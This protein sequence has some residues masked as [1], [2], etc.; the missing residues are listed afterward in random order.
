MRVLHV[1]PGGAVQPAPEGPFLPGDQPEELARPR[2]L[3]PQMPQQPGP[4]LPGEPATP[5]ADKPE[6]PPNGERAVLLGA[7]RNAVRLRNWDQALE[8]FQ[9][10]F[11]RFGTDELDARKEYLGVLVQAGR[12]R[13]ALQEYLRLLAKHPKDV[14]LRLDA[15]DIAVLNEKYH[16]AVTILLPALA[17]DPD[18][19]E[20]AVR[21]ARAYLLEDNFL[22]AV[23]VREH[24]PL[25]SLRPDDDKVPRLFP[26]L[27]LD[28]ERPAEALAFVLPLRKRMAEDAEVLASEIRIYARLC[29]HTHADEALRALAALGAGAQDVRLSLGGDLLA[30]EEFSLACQAYQQVLQIEQEAGITKSEPE[31]DKAGNGKE[32]DKPEPATSPLKPEVAIGRAKIGLARVSMHQFQPQPALMQL[33]GVVPNDEINRR[34]LL[35]WAEYHQ[36]VG[37]VIEAKAIYQKILCADPNDHE[38]RY[39]LGF[40]FESQIGEYQKAIAEYGKVPKDANQYRLAQIGIATSLTALRL[41]PEAMT[42]MKCLLDEYPHDGNAMAR[43]IRTMGKAGQGREAVPL[44][45]EFIHQNAKNPRAVLS[46]RLA[47]GQALLDCHLPQDA[48]AEYQ[49]ALDLP[50]SKIPETYYGLARAAVL[51][52]EPKKALQF[53]SA[54]EGLVGGVPRN[55]LLLSDLFDSDSD[56][57][58]ALNMV[59]PVVHYD[60][61][62]LAALIRY[63]RTQSRLARQS[64][65]IDESV[66]AAQNILKRSP[67]NVLGHIELARTFASGQHFIESAKAY[68]VLIK[69]DPSLRRPRLERARVLHSD[70]HFAEAQ[71]AYHEL[72][73]PSAEEVLEHDMAGFA[74]IDPRAKAVIGI[75]LA[76]GNLH[77]SITKAI[78]SSDPDVSLAL[79]RIQLDY[80]RRIAEQTPDRMEANDKD[81]D[82]KHYTTIKNASEVLAIEPDNNSVMFDLAQQYSILQMTH[83]AVET[84]NKDLEISPRERE[85]AIGSERATLEMSPQMSILGSVYAENGRNGLARITRLRGEV[86]FKWP[87]GDENEYLGVG[88]SRV[89]YLPHIDRP[90]DGNI[91]SGFYQGK[92]WDRLFFGGVLN[93][94]NY[95]DRISTRPTFDVD[96]H[97]AFNDFVTL[98]IGTF[99]NNVVENG[100]SM[101]QDIY[102]YAVRFG[103]DLTFTR[104]WTATGVINFGHYSD[105]NDYTEIFARSDYR[106]TLPPK[107][108]KLILDAD[109]LSYHFPSVFPNPNDPA[110]VGVIHPYFSPLFFLYYEAR[111]T[112][113]HWLS[114]D[115]F[116]HSNQCW[117]Q[118]EYALGFDNHVNM[119]N[120]LRAILNWDIKPWLS[121]GGQ[122]SCQLSDVYNEG[123]FLFYVTLRCPGSFHH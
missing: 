78:G 46:V 90:L 105:H 79:H 8:R 38:V 97:Y 114:R 31:K 2:Q 30:A 26:A 98:H 70:H 20:V 84:Y 22:Q 92:C 111:V 103:D 29:D 5:K 89:E 54:I 1:N 100:E 43:L 86:D 40:V 41:F 45:H 39:D 63:S 82:W 24:H 28:L 59:A 42:V 76:D 122:A 94:E 56:D 34:L 7:A 93:I 81:N 27:L 4:R 69:L 6:E 109:M 53:L 61:D 119:Y 121:V 120:N 99:L 37:E 9:R 74:K 19:V 64:G 106:F 72:L 52:G 77:D 60:P 17:Q 32:A 115:Y 95:A 47:L 85:A 118:L 113:K 116:T 68:E 102:R 35:A 10:Y 104:W 112:F 49:Q 16:L 87:Y 88:F 44:G 123:D 75:G 101:R 23:W 14:S 80:K 67:S 66:A 91:L 3:Q 83:K 58:G 57:H 48:F 25:S 33:Q 18:N 12:Q 55:R 65:K 21:L 13:E 73:S 108:L 110:L 51:A 96:G 15:S 117:Y 107:E 50:R 71:A 36:L 62:N 11:D